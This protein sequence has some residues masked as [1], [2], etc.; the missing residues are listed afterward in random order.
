MS[1]WNK[2]HSQY[3]D[4]LQQAESFQTFYIHD[5][6]W[7][8][9]TGWDKLSIGTI[10]DNHIYQIVSDKAFDANGNPNNCVNGSYFF[11]Q[12]TYNLLVDRDTGVFDAA[13]AYDVLQ[14]DPGEWSNFRDSIVCYNVNHD[15]AESKAVWKRKHRLHSK[16]KWNIIPVAS[17]SDLGI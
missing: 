1:S 7:N 2:Q 5:D 4:L 8:T 13:K 10:K 16:G 6:T 9:Y 12:E 11:D 14:L 3:A 17:C 15:V